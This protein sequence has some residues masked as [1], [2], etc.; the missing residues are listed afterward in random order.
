MFLKSR[1]DQELNTV[2]AAPS[3]G[4]EQGRQPNP[5]YGQVNLLWVS[6]N[7]LEGQHRKE[8][9]D[10]TRVLGFYVQKKA[11]RLCPLRA[12]LSG[13]PELLFYPPNMKFLGCGLLFLV[14]FNGIE[15]PCVLSSCPLPATVRRLRDAG[16]EKEKKRSGDNGGEGTVL[17]GWRRPLTE[18]L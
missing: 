1:R 5:V 7:N 11:G 12:L 10:Y 14:F 3:P 15:L 17:P 2:T 8:D 16:K 13:F 18:K 4:S 6:L 9:V